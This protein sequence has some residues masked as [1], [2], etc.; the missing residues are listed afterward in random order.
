MHKL[1][2][3]YVKKILQIV[4]NNIFVLSFIASC[5]VISVH[6]TFIYLILWENVRLRQYCNNH[7]VSTLTSIVEADE[8]W[9][10]I[11]NYKK[12]VTYVCKDFPP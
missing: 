9:V 1:P 6:E 4:L 10:G 11:M 2:P 5:H 3:C 12:G 7:Q 8:W